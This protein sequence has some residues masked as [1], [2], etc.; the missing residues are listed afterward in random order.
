MGDEGNRLRVDARLNR[1]RIL[2]AARVALTADPE[3]PFSSIA[4]T[5]GI[6]QGTLY[7]HF[8]SREALVL[9][10]YRQ[11]IDAL[12]ELAPRLLAE[13]PPLPAFRLW[14]DEL[15]HLGRMK[16]GIADVLHAVI[17]EQDFKETYWP[18]VAAVG[19]LM[20]ACERS[21]E[22]HPGANPQDFLLLIQFLWQTP[23]GPEGETQ[24]GRLLAFLFRGLGAEDRPTQ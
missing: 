17:S 6:G 2:D 11:E 12:V 5:A 15:A 14:C 9:A 7:R 24:A 20:Q 19:R 8:P 16:R 22:I 23:P 4:R 13:H 1:C 18:M 21:G 10:V 3:A